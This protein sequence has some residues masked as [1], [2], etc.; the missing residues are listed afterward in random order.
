MADTQLEMTEKR[1]LAYYDAE[2]SVL[3]GQSYTI[4]SKTLTRANLNE[5]RRAIKELE[6][7]IVS[8][9][10]NGKRI[11]KRVIPRDL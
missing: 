3:S 7:Q 9:N 11:M 8:L 6:N 10:K 2:I 1:L 5:I 4:G